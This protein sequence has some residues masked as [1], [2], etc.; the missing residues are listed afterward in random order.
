MLDSYIN[1]H[2]GLPFAAKASLLDVNCYA[3]KGTSPVLSQ[4]CTHY[5]E[6]LQSLLPMLVWNQFLRQ[7]L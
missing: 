2:F 7:C 4:A 1:L 3:R 5:T 6:H